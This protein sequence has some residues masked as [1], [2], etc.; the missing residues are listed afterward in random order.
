MQQE[1]YEIV[2]RLLNNEE[3]RSIADTLDVSYSKVLRFKRE[4]TEHLANDT[5]NEFIDLDAA[6]LN[7]LTQLAKQSVP[8]ALVG[9]ADKAIQ[10]LITAKSTL[11]VLSVEL[12]STARFLSSRIKTAA[13]T[14][15]TTSELETLSLALCNLQNAFFNKNSTQVNVQNNYSAEQG[16]YGNLLDD[17]PTDY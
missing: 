1:K 17:K 16:K 8:E 15:T 11:E 13:S 5:L 6:M 7:E 4:L 2:S 9:E 10:G 3:P 12:Q 14:I